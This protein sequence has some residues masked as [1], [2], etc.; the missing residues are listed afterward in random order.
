M[1]HRDLNR[2]GDSHVETKPT[3]G[4]ANWKILLAKNQHNEI[5]LAHEQESEHVE[6][7]FS[8]NDRL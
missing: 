4:A 5:F 2:D 6:N 1:K 7:V 3:Q 8:L